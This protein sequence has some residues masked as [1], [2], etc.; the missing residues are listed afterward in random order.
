[1]TSGDASSWRRRDVSPP[2]GGDVLKAEFPY[3]AGETDEARWRDA[4][5]ELT[6]AIDV[7]WV[8]LSGGVDAATFEAQVRVACAAG[9]SGVL[10]GRSI[11]AEAAT[12][13]PPR[14]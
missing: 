6:A 13:A 1:M 9:A 10:A 14:A 5:E 8:L 4:C 3:D 12:M 11:W 7:P 2:L